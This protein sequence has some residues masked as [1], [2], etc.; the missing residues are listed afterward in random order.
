MSNYLWAL[1]MSAADSSCGERRSV[2]NMFHPCL[3]AVA[4]T[5]WIMAGFVAPDWLRRLDRRGYRAW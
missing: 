4:S 3:Q 1:V 5:V 2:S